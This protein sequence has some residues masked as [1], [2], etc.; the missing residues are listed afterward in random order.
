MSVD[1]KT[2]EGQCFCGAVTIEVTGDPEGAGYCHCK[3]CRSWSAGPVN[4][5]TLWKPEAVKVTKGDGPDRRV[6]PQRAELAPVVQGLRRP[7]AHAA[8]ELGSGR[9]LRGDDS[10][11]SVHARRPRQLRVDGA[12]DE[13]R[14]SEAQGLPGGAGR[15]RRGDRRVVPLHLAFPGPCDLP[16]QR[17]V[18]D[19]MT[20]RPDQRHVGRPKPASRLDVHTH[21]PLIAAFAPIGPAEVHNRVNGPIRDLGGPLVVGAIERTKA[22]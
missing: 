7:S 14:P 16:H 6:P 18:D 19:S 13:G 1:E 3:N 12:A 4:A 9:C 21:L 15:D 2:Y 20:K 11:V 17:R 22:V 10:L 8:P 5:F